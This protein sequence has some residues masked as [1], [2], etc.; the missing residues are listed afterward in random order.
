MM[1][2]NAGTGERLVILP[3]RRRVDVGKH[4]DCAG[5]CVGMELPVYK[6]GSQVCRVS[7]PFPDFL[8]SGPNFMDRHNLAGA[9]NR[10]YAAKGM[11]LK[12]LPVY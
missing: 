7:L 8:H 5:S 9:Y 6:E 4:W 10:A 2:G 12:A 11:H 3:Y 1:I